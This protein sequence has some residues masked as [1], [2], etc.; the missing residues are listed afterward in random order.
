MLNLSY[1]SNR[2]E[3][4]FIYFIFTIM[5]KPKEQPILSETSL[6]QKTL[7]KIERIKNNSPENFLGLFPEIGK[8]SLK[9]W[10][11][12]RLALGMEAFDTGKGKYFEELYETLYEQEY[13]QELEEQAR[14][15]KQGIEI[16]T[17]V[18][19]INKKFLKKFKPEF[20]RKMR[21]LLKERLSLEKKMN[22]AVKAKNNSEILEKLEGAFQNLIREAIETNNL[23]YKIRILE[24]LSRQSIKYLEGNLKN[25]IQTVILD[26]YQKIAAICT[27]E[28]KKKIKTIVKSV[29]LEMLQDKKRTEALKLAQD[30]EKAGLLDLEKDSAIFDKLTK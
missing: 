21:E 14:K 13:E 5:L 12:K 1:L 11:E 19:E 26:E 3:P 24:T 25:N 20:V 8:E 10:E 23:D 2:Q 27:D 18:D 17:E 7:E 28:Q 15:G 4:I 16:T 22:E 6:D 30:F 29:I 9:N